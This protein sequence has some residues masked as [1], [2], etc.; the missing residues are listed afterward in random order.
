MQELQLSC[1]QEPQLDCPI[2]SSKQAGNEVSVLQDLCRRSDETGDEI[3][4]LQQQHDQMDPWCAELQQLHRTFSDNAARTE[5]AESKVLA[6][7]SPVN[8][9]NLHAVNQRYMMALK[10][11]QKVCHSGRE[12]V[13]SLPIEG[14]LSST[15][16]L[17]FC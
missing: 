4:R 16:S 14:D 13:S 10:Q 17:Q 12:L 9:A 2:F 11:F 8:A 15:P 1:M 6:D 3:E 7:N 5:A